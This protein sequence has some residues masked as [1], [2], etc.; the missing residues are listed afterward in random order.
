MTAE[1]GDFGGSLAR[2]L[3]SDIVGSPGSVTE[4]R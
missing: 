2:A 3:A 1:A 4:A